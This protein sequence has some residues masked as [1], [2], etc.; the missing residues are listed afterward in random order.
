MIRRPDANPTTIKSSKIE[1]RSDSSH[2]DCYDDDEDSILFCT[3]TR[4]GDNCAT[5]NE[6]CKASC[7]I[8]EWKLQLLCACCHASVS[9]YFTV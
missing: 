4:L 3:A 6:T 8:C 9:V 2:Y 5:A 7:D 1:D